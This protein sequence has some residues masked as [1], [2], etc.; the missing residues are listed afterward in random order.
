MKSKGKV[1][2]VIVEKHHD[3]FVAYPIGMNGI[4]VGQGDSV[5]EAL[6]N[7]RSAIEFHIKT[8]GQTALADGPLE[9]VLADIHVSK[10]R[11]A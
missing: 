1:V 5:D 11:S 8:F 6:E 2:K 3:G 7:V 10:G 9:I 4:V